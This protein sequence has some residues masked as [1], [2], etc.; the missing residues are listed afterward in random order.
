MILIY[1][2]V[3]ANKWIL[4]LQ[5]KSWRNPNI[6]HRN[7]IYQQTLISWPTACLPD[8]QHFICCL[9]SLSGKT[10]IK[11]NFVF[12]SI[13]RLLQ[14]VNLSK[15]QF[16]LRIKCCVLQP[17]ENGWEDTFPSEAY[18]S[19]KA[20]VFFAVVIRYTPKQNSTLAKNASVLKIFPMTP[21]PHI[22][23]KAKH[24]WNL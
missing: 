15:L 17:V 23:S 6:S 9:P 4:E 2:A 8:S 24:S 5:K 11:F 18:E 22:H 16:I 1:S 10:V 14:S 19:C 7:I 20:Y 12:T 3:C 13:H 21:H